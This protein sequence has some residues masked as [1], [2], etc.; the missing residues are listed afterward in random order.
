MR[1]RIAVIA[2]FFATA[3]ACSADQKTV[4]AKAETGLWGVDTAYISE[5][6]APGD[7]FYLYVNEGWIDQAVF[8][9]GFSFYN[10]PWARQTSIYDELDQ[11]F[12]VS[13][14]SEQGPSLANRQVSDFRESFLNRNKINQ[15]ALAPIQPDLERIFALES[16]DDVAGFMGD[17]RASSIFHLL[18]QPPVNMKGGYVLTIAQYRTTG[19]G[20]PSQAHY[21]SD[22]VS[23]IEN[24]AAYQAYIETVF[25]LAG[26]KNAAGH[27]ANVLDLER[28]YAAIMWDFSRLR[29]AGSAFNLVRRD[30]LDQYAPGF[31]WE[32]FLSER[33]VHTVE[34]IN[35]GAGALK[36]SAALFQDF[37]IDQWQSFLAFHWINSHAAILPDGF[38]KAHFSFFDKELYGVETEESLEQRAL[39]FTRRYIGEQVGRLYVEH[40]F[41]NSREDALMEMLP[42]IFAAF[43][44]RLEQSDWMDAATRAEAIKKLDLILVEP[45]YPKVG[46]DWMALETS[47]MNA[48]ANRKNAMELRWAYQVDRLGKPISRYGDWNMNAH[49]IGMGYHQQYN[50]IFI[51]AGALQAPFFDPAADMAVNFGAVG[52]TLAHEFGHAL[53]DQGAQFDSN[54]A[55]RDWWHAATRKNYNQRTNSLI[56]QFGNYETLPGSPLQSRQMIGEIVGDLVG[57]SIA[58]RAYQLYLEDHSQGSSQVLDGYSAEQR[59]FLGAAQQTRAIATEQV[60]R[61]Q[62]L[63]ASHPPAEFR[64]NGIL[65]NFDPWYAAF[66]I[67]ENDELFLPSDERIRLW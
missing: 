20:L 6:V 33:G 11:L 23:Y 54:G 22:N 39:N 43:R 46:P 26:V 32:S 49:H 41:S 31:P 13:A 64:I 29:E 59:F 2:A 63:N 36:E 48:V 60:L 27:A 53:D 51:T 56:E 17:V 14:E 37:S 10:E 62:A 7:N 67:D 12:A 45:G 35:I 15:S 4:S 40:Y 8:P 38:A 16:Y 21:S 61:S 28:A 25:E 57:I 30:E 50:K 18:V 1:I 5:V 42:Y 3:A 66:D 19:L 55:L 52:Q 47:P 44:E 9:P 65:R 34:K 24:R 58:F